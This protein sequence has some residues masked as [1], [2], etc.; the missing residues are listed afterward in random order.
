M[1]TPP[2]LA[3]TQGW[4]RRSSY[5][6]ARSSACSN[7]LSRQYSVGL[8]ISRLRRFAV[9]GRQRTSISNTRRAFSPR[10]SALASSSR[11]S[12]SRPSSALAGVIIG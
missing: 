3:P 2:Q 1:T 7:P 4:V 8:R 12:V 6:R 5:V 11:P 9:Y 10:N